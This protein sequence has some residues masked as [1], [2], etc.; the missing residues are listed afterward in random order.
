MDKKA[1][2]YYFIK[3]YDRVF[4]L[5]E[6]LCDGDGHHNQFQEL[7]SQQQEWYLQHPDA[8]AHEVKQ[9]RTDLEQF[10]E[11]NP[12]DQYKASLCIQLSAIAE[13]RIGRLVPQQKLNDAVMGT[14]TQDANLRAG[15]EDRIR[16]YRD[17]RDAA[18]KEISRVRLAISSAST[19]Q[20]AE[21]AYNSHH[22]E[23]IRTGEEAWDE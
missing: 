5:D 17:I 16:Y 3:G 18:R 23:E 14:G 8:S 9:L 13:S 12:L 2:Y 22:L 11:D 15:Y 21:A 19:H 4:S 7:S 20:E 1:R 10:Q 6:R